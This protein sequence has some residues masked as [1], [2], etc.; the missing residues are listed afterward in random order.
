MHPAPDS[1]PQTQPGGT[2]RLLSLNIQVGLHTSH[3][4]HYVT[5]AWRHVLPTSGARA[6][7][8]R[9]ATLAARYDIV[10]LQEADAGSLRTAQL[11]QVA[12]LAER[13]GFRYW[14][15]AVTR[16]LR[17]FA[18]HC[19]GCLS[20]WPLKTVQYHGLP[21]WLPGRGA[22]E[23]E[24]QPEGCESLRL[25]IVH[26]ALGRAARARQLDFLA[27]LV[28]DRTDT[29]VLG[30]LNCDVSELAGH[31]GVRDAGLRGVH[32]EHT[33]PSW[34]P[35]RSLDHILVTPTVEVISATVL[36]ERLSDHLP[37]ATEIRLR[38]EGGA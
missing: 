18:Q 10:A 8:E 29:I 6:N 24:I 11:N 35:S 25:I 38:L 16:D 13:A 20:R 34:R 14:H 4:R 9:I 3:Y 21:G 2:L 32:S 31:H 17:P 33:F 23:V 27:T 7:L 12:H 37:V 1:L 22:L 19:L 26:L 36:D 30:D 15:A 28:K 5:Q